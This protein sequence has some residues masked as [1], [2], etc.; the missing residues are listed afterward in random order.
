VR[1]ANA[2]RYGLAGYVWTSDLRRAHTVAQAIDSGM[3][4]VNAQNVRDLSMPFGGMKDSGIGREGG[5][6]SFEFYCE[7]QAV[8]IALGEHRIPRLGLGDGGH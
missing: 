4:W 5:H 8:H 2:T 3:V 7:L 1:L 6:H